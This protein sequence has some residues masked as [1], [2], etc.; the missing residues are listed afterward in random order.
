M[1]APSLRTMEARLRAVEARLADL[2]GPYAES[3]Y[4]L[5]RSSVRQDLRMVRVLE[6]LGVE[7]VTDEEVDAV[8]DE[9]A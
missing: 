5:R 7:D 2:E 8:L 3:I 4:Q 1:A 9:E 6:H